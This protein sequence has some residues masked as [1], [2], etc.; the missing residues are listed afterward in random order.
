[1]T[2]TI[3]VNKLEYLSLKSRLEHAEAQL[4]R[5]EMIWIPL[6]NCIVTRGYREMVEVNGLLERYG[7][8][9]VCRL[10]KREED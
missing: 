6:G 9:Q 3:E 5:L 10:V 7:D 4:S 2:E 1:M 8:T